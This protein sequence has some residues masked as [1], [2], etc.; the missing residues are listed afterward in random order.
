MSEEQ[1]EYVTGNDNNWISVKDKL[2]DVNTKM[3]VLVQCLNPFFGLLTSDIMLGCY[4]DIYNYTDDGISTGEERGWINWGSEPL[5]KILVTHWMPL[6]K[7][8]TSEFDGIKQEDFKNRFGSFEP[9]MG[10]VF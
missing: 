9:K 4:D 1:A 5:F 2:P 10:N 7:K 3:P 8:I 6:P